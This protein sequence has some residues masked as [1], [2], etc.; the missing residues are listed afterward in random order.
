MK[1]FVI[2]AQPRTG[3]SMLVNTLNT[4]PNFNVYGE[5]FV[6]AKNMLMN[7][8]DH[9]Q[10][11]QREMVL[12]Y[13]R[14]SYDLSGKSVR[15]FLISIYNQPGYVGFKLLFPHLKRKFGSNIIKYIQDNNIYKI[16]LYRKNKIKQVI[17]AQTNKKTE[18]VKV[19]VR[20]VVDKIK[21]LIQEQ[22]QYDAV[23]ANGNFPLLSNIFPFTVICFPK[24]EED[25]RSVVSSA[26]GLYPS[27]R[28]S[29]LVNA[30]RTEVEDKNAIPV[31]AIA[32][33]RKNNLLEVLFFI[34]IWLVF[35]YTIINFRTK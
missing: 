14:N 30:W 17:S 32:V 21:F 23:F 20:Q 6:R 28:D 10:E 34:I 29:S 7:P 4:L 2:I 19:D 22:K 3:T 5:L 33:F 8:V 1:K 12:R 31:V 26:Y 24:R 27:K 18:K 13:I 35:K 9:P 15:D 16:L 25:L 11:V